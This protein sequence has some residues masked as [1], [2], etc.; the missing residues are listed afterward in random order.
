L[1][2]WGWLMTLTP[3]RAKKLESGI[4]FCVLVVLFLIAAAILL[5][6]SR[7]NINR[8]GI[9]AQGTEP[10]AAGQDRGGE[11]KIPLDSLAPPGFVATGPVETYT[12]EN[13]Y[14]KI[15]G[16][17][18][19]YTDSGFVKLLVRRFTS[20][21][22][23][24]LSI[25]LYI[26]DMG[27]LKN[28]FSVY[29]RQRRPDAQSLPGVQFGYKSENALYFVHGRYYCELIASSRYDE[30]GQAMERLC[31]NIRN[32]LAVDSASR[33]PELAL[34]P[35]EYLVPGSIKLYL[36]DAFG[37]EGLTDT[38]CARY[39][40][41]GQE[42]TAFLSRRSNPQQA[43]NLAA[44]YTDFLLEMGGSRS[45]TTNKTLEKLNP[46]IVDLSGVTEIVFSIEAF[47]AG[48]HE[49]ENRQLAEKVAVLL[50]KRLAEATDARD[51]E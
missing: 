15:D 11:E 14:E 50:G 23:E 40:I 38:F 8:F 44:G 3:G 16:K 51:Y 1:L 12:A 25:E 10:T 27:R 31:R 9:V 47:I 24:Q 36:N 28:A 18:S 17:A 26:Y 4:S 19:F 13:L 21:Q 34:F 37:Y 43:L 32:S 29:S 41:D 48:I 39:E 30:L 22:N 20:E 2:F 42:V 45:K 49:A 35:K 5:K 7:S 6:Q 33:M 46:Q